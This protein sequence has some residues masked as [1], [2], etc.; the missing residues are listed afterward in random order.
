L[1]LPLRETLDSWIMAWIVA[2]LLLTCLNLAWKAVTKENLVDFLA[3]RIFGVP[4]RPLL[5]I[6]RAWH[7]YEVRHRVN[8]RL[9]G[10]SHLSARE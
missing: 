3:S 9:V 10:Y 2:L 8:D 7:R 1:S 5:Y 6:Q 4:A